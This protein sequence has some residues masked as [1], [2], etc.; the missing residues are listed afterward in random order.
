MYCPNCG[1]HVDDEANFCP[2]CG[3]PL[4][5]SREALAENQDGSA[6]DTRLEMEETKPEKASSE[7]SSADDSSASK[8]RK[9]GVMAATV[10]IAGFAVPAFAA[11]IAGA[12]ALG[13]VAY[14][15][16]AGAGFLP[17]QQQDEQAVQTE[18]QPDQEQLKEEAQAAYEKVLDEYRAAY[19]VDYDTYVTGG[20]GK[21]EYPDVNWGRIATFRAFPDPVHSFYTLLDIDGDGVDELFIA[22]LG[23]NGYGDPDDVDESGVS[24]EQFTDVYAAYDYDGNGLVTLWQ[25]S[26]SYL[27]RY[28]LC[29]DN[30][31]LH[32]D[33]WSGP[34]IGDTIVTGSGADSLFSLQP[35]HS[36]QTLR[37]LAWNADATI[38][39]VDFTYTDENG[40]SEE[41]SAGKSD[42][43]E[44]FGNAS[45]SLQDGYPWRDDI[46]WTMIH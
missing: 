9:A 26:D 6:S 42:V 30:A 11:G 7:E 1:S 3:M 43:I 18:A 27:D 19:T 34:Y 21:E 23:G 33:D 46:A 17:S 28:I 13:A 10:N 2:E 35:D 45:K 38:G 41:H 8:K 24:H 16:A 36:T 39:K 32:L 37:K 29:Q 31:V 4:Q 20:K 40:S 22:M 25:A 14:A 15:V 12:V 44:A 5:E